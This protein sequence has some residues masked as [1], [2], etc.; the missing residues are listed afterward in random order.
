MTNKTRHNQL[1]RKLM[2]EGLKL[3]AARGIAGCKVEDITRAAEV[4]KGTFFNLF[5]SKDDFVAHAVDYCLSDLNRR[6]SPL[7]FSTAPAEQLL[8]SLGGVYLR[9]F[10]LRPEVAALLMQALSLDTNGPVG[11]KIKEMFSNHLDSSAALAEKACQALGWQNNSRE[12]VLSLFSLSC[13]FFW[14]GRGLVNPP[15]PLLERL[16]KVLAKGLT[17][18]N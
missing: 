5:A 1:K 12:L 10:Q 9:Y 14:V 15:G 16:S 6:L 3:M 4:G 17:P 18:D 8:A 7:S 2:D 13:G 11:E